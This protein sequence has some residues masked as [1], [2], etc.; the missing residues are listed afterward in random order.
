MCCLLEPLLPED[1]AQAQRAASM[2]RL[3]CARLAVDRVRPFSLMLALMRVTAEVATDNFAGDDSTEYQGLL[4]A[5]LKEELHAAAARK[6][7]AA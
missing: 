4:L 2:L 5:H 6:L 3:C 7:E 1:I